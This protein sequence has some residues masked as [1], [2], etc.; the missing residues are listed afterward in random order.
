M[1]RPNPIWESAPPET[2]ARSPPVACRRRTGALTFPGPALGRRWSGAAAHLAAHVGEEAPL[3]RREALDPAR[4]DLVEHTIDFSLRRIALG[5]TGLW[6]GAGA[7]RAG[8]MHLQARLRGAAHMA[9]PARQPPVRH[10]QIQQAGR[11]PA[12]VGEVRHPVARR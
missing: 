11:E 1:E 8:G 3:R 9:L 4:R 6:G 12:E 10:L 2:S 5:P 7:R